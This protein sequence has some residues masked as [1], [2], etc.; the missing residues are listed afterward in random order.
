MYFIAQLFLPRSTNVS[1]SIEQGASVGLASNRKLEDK[2]SNPKTV[3]SILSNIQ[4][5]ENAF[6]A[7]AGPN[8]DAGS[9]VSPS[10]QLNQPK[11]SSIPRPVA[12]SNSFSS[13]NKSGSNVQATRTA[14]NASVGRYLPASNNSKAFL[15]NKEQRNVN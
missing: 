14:S 10:G 9:N 1:K 2:S 11:R 5:S 15:P 6:Q 12:A 8:N 7:R 13:G 3:T 4:G